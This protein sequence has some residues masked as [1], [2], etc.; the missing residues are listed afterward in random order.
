MKTFKPDSGTDH[1]QDHA[2]S[3]AAVPRSLRS[4]V[5][6]AAFVVVVAGMRAAESLL[7]PFLLSI[8]IAVICAPPLFWLQ[9][10]KV[11]TA[12]ALILVILGVLSVGAALGALVGTSIDDFRHS[13]PGYQS[14]LQAETAGLFSWLE[15]RGLK[16][17]RTMVREHFDPGAAMG[18]ASRMLSGL[19]SA[20]A[21]GFLI[22]LTVIFIL[23]EAAGLPGKLR[24]AFGDPGA[25]L[26]GLDRF[27]KN[28]KQYMAI[29]TLVSLIT[30]VGIAVWLAVVGV[31]YPVLWGILAFFLN[32]V[33]NIGSIIAAVPAVLL[34]FVQL[35]AGSALLGGAGFVVVNVVV[36]NGLE[37][38]LMGRGL[39]LSTL[40]VFI[41]LVFWG[42][43]LGPVGM[44][45]S[46]PLTM[47][48]KIALDSSEETRWIAVLLGPDAGEPPVPVPEKTQQ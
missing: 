33:P 44:L 30:G 5:G 17:S 26:G 27:V 42:W 1:R 18:L 39:G 16:L 23:L 24:A 4:L 6:G 3:A 29:K 41:S 43:V 10:K 28:L 40:V 15:E 22:L 11:P 13:L 14:R 2:G 45:L 37:P 7:V 31:D 35:G 47:T 19:G 21:N 38:R 36:G 12:V 46:V 25:S 9:R 32:Y 48:V 34:A 8:F 20:L